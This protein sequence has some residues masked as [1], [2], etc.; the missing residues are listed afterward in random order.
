MKKY[1]N[2]LALLFCLIPISQSFAIES[3]KLQ[4]V[5]DNVYAIVGELGNRTPENLG[6]NATF[7][8]VV[9]SEGVV[10]IDSGATYKGAKEIH[11]L[12]KSFTNK[13]IT[14]VINTGGQDHRWLGNGYFK[15]QGARRMASRNTVEDQKTRTQDQFISRGSLVGDSVIT[16]QQTRCWERTADVSPMVRKR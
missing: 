7:G 14:T 16:G 11:R 6:N 15:E 10:L 4:K 9:T 5:T 1:K 12:I 2:L 3:L 8:L 13:P